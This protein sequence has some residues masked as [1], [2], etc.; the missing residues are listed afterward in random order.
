VLPTRAQI[1]VLLVLGGLLVSSPASAQYDVYFRGRVIREDGSVPDHGVTVQR[2]C[3]GLQQPIREGTTSRKTGEYVVRLYVNELGQVYAGMGAF[4]SLPCSLEASASGFVSSRLDLTDRR[5][6]LRPRLPDIVLTPKSHSVTLE[7]Y[8]AA[9]MPRGASRNWQLAV[10]RLT[11]RDWDGAEAPL[12]A[13]VQTAPRFGPA[14]AALGNVCLRQGKIEEARRVL[15]RAVELDPKQLSPY[16]MLAQTQADLKDWRA[17]AATTERLV[18]A[19]SKHVYVEAYL[20]SAA[21]LYQLR[22]YDQALV[23]INDA[24]RLDR[25]RELKRAAY[26][27]GLILEAKGDYAAAEKELRSYL[28]ENPR[29]KEAAA[30]NERIANLGKGPP[31]DLSAELSSLDL[32][33]AATGEAPVPGGI[34]AFSTIAQLDGTPSPHD[35]FLEYCRAITAGSPS[36]P[37]RTREAREELSS[38]I[39]AVGALESMGERSE[40][41]KLIRLSTAGDAEVRKT[42]AIL[43]ELG[44]KLLAKGEGYSIEAVGQHNDG[45]RQRALV[46]LGVE[47]LDLRSALRERREFTFEIPNETAR[48]V[49]G[50]AWS[51]L[52]KGVPEANG[53]P[54]EIFIR[55]WR[56]ARVYSGLGGMDPDS[57]SAL[58]SAVGLAN[59]IV[60][61][62]ALTSAYA[63]AVEISG[64]R[65]AVPG[66]VRAE[67][68]WAKLLG[69]SPQAIKP[70]LRALFEKDQGRL[71]A[72][73]H[74]LAQADAPHQQFFTQTTERAEGFYKWYRDSAPP[75]GSILASK[76]WQ[77]KILQSL[78]IDASGKVL[79]PGGREAWGTSSETDDEILL[80]RAPLEALAAVALL[81]QQRGTPV[82]R[83]AA[84]LLA[85]H[86]GEWR[87]LFPYFDKLPGLEEP[88]F[89]ALEDFAAE[90]ARAPDLQRNLLLGEWHSLVQ[91]IVLGSQAG[92]LT[93]SQAERAFRQA[94]TAL[95]PPNPS[96][97]ALAVVRVIAGGDAGLD[98][99][100]A[101]RLLRLN[102]PRREAFE[103]LK[104][105]Q[106]VPRLGGLELE[107]DAT[108]TLEA[109]SGAVYAA[110]LDPGYL[111][112]AE[113]RQLLRRHR[114]VTGD[115]QGALFPESSLTVSNGPSGCN[116]EG[117]F[118]SFQEA[119]QPLGSRTVGTRLLEAHQTAALPAQASG[120]LQ[121]ASGGTETAP[122]AGGDLVFQARG[123]VVEVYAT[124]TDNRGRYVDN[125]NAGQFTIL[126]ESEARPVSAFE[127]YMAGVSVALVFDTTGSM[128]STL[129]RLKSAALQL[130]DELRPVDSAAVYTFNDTVTAL[131]PF[132]EDK[133]AAKRAI[134]KLH[135]YGVT[136]L[137][138]A[139]VRVNHD[140]AARPGKKVIVVFTDGADN[141]SMVSS[142]LAIERAKERGI[143]IYTIAQGEAL[144]HP[145]L[146]AEL[147]HISRS[148]GGT[149]FLI[150]SMSDMAEVFAK[151]SQDLKHGYLVVFRPS[152]GENR[153][154]RK[155]EVV[156]SGSKGLQVRAREGYYV[157]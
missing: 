105:L 79:F 144:S 113:D 66:G 109:L 49:G 42:R 39:S 63:D 50:A 114:F 132:T 81:E 99:S 90:A 33:L 10:K 112:V 151:I 54:A 35:F 142:D 124:V 135:A 100:L 9:G 122:A 117:G 55:D 44:W 25:L 64:K 62:S 157:E 120:P 80:R 85:R 34:K 2:V 53:G 106:D 59:L 134:L 153:V 126:E 89:R 139:L 56:F 138:E 6:T 38:F 147:N 75:P 46:G 18:A 19:D 71:L 57:A 67:P 125:L 127:S 15:E 103:D 1:L 29:A 121:E 30:V 96:A 69:A 41:G 52:L 150:R 104:K 23:R 22:D 155:I 45:L 48:L 116:F 148:T 95:R 140:L 7:I 110:M 36:Q 76:G 129:P 21:A 131:L 92:S 143:P 87:S 14:W 78:R 72:F 88:A 137:Y 73:Y 98:E 123:R 136:A 3:Y 83:P 84:Q 107:P 77:Q 145:E 26:I 118:A 86:Y 8:P 17:V 149:P 111:L 97:A 20:L 28:A 65:V 5:I 119:A 146:V 130:L 58:V 27:R 156:L 43:A 128:E 37:N 101:S 24:V 32:S 16:Q 11:T 141:A 12:R 133:E 31:A 94:C 102:G 152:P 47:E 82:S 93:A 61:Y 4:A 108:K 51:V 68:V 115:S 74:D 154:W 40:R 13:V 91:L 70:F 60:K